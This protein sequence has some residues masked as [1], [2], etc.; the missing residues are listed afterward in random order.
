MVF[1][2]FQVCKDIKEA[3]YPNSI[4]LKYNFV[5]FANSNMDEDRMDAYLD[6]VKCTD[7]EKQILKERYKEG[8][9][10]TDIGTQFGLTSSQVSY[11]LEKV[12]TK[13]IRLLKRCDELVEVRK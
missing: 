8:K 4:L 9:P 6:L 10:L 13:L 11:R 3:G 12:L 7:L 2:A 1:D 5:Q